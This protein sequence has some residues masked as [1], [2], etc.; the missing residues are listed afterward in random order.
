ML[1]NGNATEFHKTVC[2]SCH[3]IPQIEDWIKAE[4][5]NELHIFH[6]IKKQGMWEPF[7]IGTNSEPYFDERLSWEGRFNKLTQVCN[8]YI[9]D[10]ILNFDTIVKKILTF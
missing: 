6:T 2:V 3:N 9:I 4:I 10:K 5:K 8:N 7:Y 1:Q